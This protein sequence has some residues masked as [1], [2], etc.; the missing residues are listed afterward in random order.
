MRGRNLPD[1]MPGHELRP[2]T[3]GF[4]QPEQGDFDREQRGLGE[5][6][7]VQTFG[8]V[9]R[10]A[11]RAARSA[12]QTS[13]NARRVHREAVVQ[14][15]AHAHP[16]RA[17]AGEDHREPARHDAAL[18]HVP[19]TAAGRKGGKPRAELLGRGPEHDGPVFERAAPG[20]QRG[21]RARKVTV[22]VRDER[23]G[24]RAQGVRAPGRDQPW[25]RSRRRGHRSRHGFRLF[26]DHVRVG[27][28][29]PE[30]RHAR[31]PGPVTGIPLL[32]RGQ[33]P[34]RA[35]GPV[36]LRRRPVHVQRPREDAVPHRHHHLDHAGDPGR[37]LRVPEVR[38]HR[39][40]P[41]RGFPVAAVGFQ[42]RLRFDRIAQRGPGAVRLDDVDVRGGQ[43]GRREGGGDHPPLGRPVG[44]GEAVRRAVGVHRRAA[45]DRQHRVPV[46]P[47]VRQ[48]FDQQQAGAFGPAGAVGRVGER[49]APPVGGQAALPVELG[50][51][52]RGGH[53]GDPAGDREAALAASQRLGGEV[54]RDQRRRARGVDRDR[55]ALQ[56][57]VVGQP[58]GQH[59]ARRPG[60]QVAGD[61]VVTAGGAVPRRRAADEHAGTAA[62]QGLRRDPGPFQQFPRR[63]QQQPLLR[64]HG[65]RLAG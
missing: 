17:L 5:L 12:A 4:E 57:E 40:Q 35:R 38:L 37:R 46:P 50:E 52:A 55:R 2:D 16:L 22:G 43:P 14:F 34:D 10:F 27:P 19:R 7:A 21:A 26:E 64:V 47:G 28:G 29:D 15:P 9:E 31:P 41:Q 32:R 59:A 8:V 51:G 45:Q 33:Q 60:E 49:L 18:H 56:A 42:Q 58:A 30:R 20:E 39:T 36:H 6:G 13:S 3:E 24:L 63:L 54:Q 65:E 11:Q 61:L 44:G 53:H 1:R 62:A 48:P 23:G 25:D